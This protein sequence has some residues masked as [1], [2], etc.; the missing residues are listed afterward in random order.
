ML[1]AGGKFGGGG[2]AIAG[3]LHGVG[4][5]VVNA[6]SRR[7]EATNCRDGHKYTIAFAYGKVVEPFT[8]VGETDAHGLSVRFWP[9]DGIFEETVFDHDVVKA[10]LREQ[11][12]LNA[13]V[14]ITLR[15]ERGRRCPNTR[16][17]ATRGGIKSF[18][19][20]LNRKKAAELLH[21]E[22]IYVS[23]SRERAS[24]RSRC[25]T[26]TPITRPSSRSPTIYAHRRRRH[27]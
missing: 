5:S 15:D 19:E 21:E 6:L 26:T 20:Y 27:A 10:R 22:I 4:A 9:D 25:S 14:K 2:Y 12:F 11:A 24:R 16:N 1:H 17:S 23:G 13:G 18:V 8:C 7:L 3:G